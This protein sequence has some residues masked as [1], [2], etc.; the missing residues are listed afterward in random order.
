MSHYP[1]PFFFDELPGRTFPAGRLAQRAILYKVKRRPSF[2]KPKEFVGDG[3]RRAITDL[4][5]APV[6]SIP[7]A[8]RRTLTRLPA[9]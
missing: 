4:S 5:L 7:T 2:V 3:V 1:N 8:A 9:V 6:H